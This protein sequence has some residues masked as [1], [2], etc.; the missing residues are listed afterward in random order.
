MIRFIFVFML[1][2]LP[3][4][5]FSQDLP[6]KAPERATKIVHIQHG[7]PQKIADLLLHVGS[8]NLAADN[9]LGIIL[10]NGIP[11]NVAR[12]EQT[13]KQLDVAPAVSTGNDIEVVVYLVGASSSS[14]QESTKNPPAI[15]PVIKQL[16][17]IFP[18]KSYGLL[19]TMLLRSQQGKSAETSGILN[20]SFNSGKPPLPSTYGIAYDSAVISSDKSKA[21]IHLDH[22]RFSSRISIPTSSTGYQTFEIG[23]KSDVDIREG[24]K[25]VVGKTD[26]ANDGS[27]IFV[28]LTAK[29]VD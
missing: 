18:Y 14:V 1:A 26:V 4:V 3:E 2:V 11:E 7:N 17:S 22:L 12:A 8:I 20:Y 25:V 23:T 19:G 6:P 24:Q 29:L 5:V 13:I 21:I 28:V 9:A 16:G 27:A 15:E 10:L